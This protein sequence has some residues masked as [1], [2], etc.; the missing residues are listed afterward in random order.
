MS[1]FDQTEMRKASLSLFLFGMVLSFTARAQPVVPNELSST[2]VLIE[3]PLQGQSGWGTG[4][5]M[6]C[7]NTIFLV[8]A[9]HVLFD[10]LPSPALSVSDITDLDVLAAKLKQPDAND[11]VSRY[12]TNQLSPETRK[13]LV[14]FDR[15]ANFQ[16]KLT[17]ARHLI[18]DANRIICSPTFYD[19]LRFTNVALS[20]Q[21]SIL[22]E[23]HPQGADLVRLN[24]MLLQDTYPSA[25]SNKFIFAKGGVLRGPMAR[26][27][28]HGK[29]K[30]TGTAGRNELALDL[31][32][33]TESQV[34][35]R[36][37]TRDVTV[38]PLGEAV[39]AATSSRISINWGAGVTNVFSTESGF[40]CQGM[41][42]CQLFTNVD[43]AADTV[44]LGYPVSL[45]NPQSP[46]IDLE[47]PIFIRGAV[48]QRNQKSGRLILTSQV[49]P[50]DSGGPVFIMGHPSLG[51]TSFLLAGIVV[52]FIPVKMDVAPLPGVTTTANSGYGVV[53]PIDYAIELMRK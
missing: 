22:R 19:A 37:L 32:S 24:R 52:E 48:S 4:L 10:P 33:L 34:V 26:L 35:R 42:G 47:E 25:L 36:H 40:H 49:Y 12:V 5:Y 31:K 23:Q 18:E 39:D 28:G 8:T 11:S 27:R 41:D 29:P 2:A 7:S 38:I 45:W 1:S 44:V 14:G 6:A 50:G 21:T 43:N 30:M 17:F 15:N 20:R 53:E 3:L 9:D 51:V 13:L 46:A 16:L